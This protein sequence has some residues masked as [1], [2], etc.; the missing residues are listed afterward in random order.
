MTTKQISTGVLDYP[1]RI[2]R[3]SILCDHVERIL[4]QDKLKHAEENSST[5]FSESP[6][7]DT[8]E[9]LTFRN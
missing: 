4:S 8:K 5:N 2:G 6:V 1:G 9:D 7:M 3:Q